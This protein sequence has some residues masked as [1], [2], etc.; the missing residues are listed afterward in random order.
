[1]YDPNL[2]NSA[3]NGAYK[4]AILFGGQSDPAFGGKLNTIQNGDY[5]EF[6]PRIGFAWSRFE[7][8]SFRGSYGI[9][10]SPRDAENYTDGAL[11]LGL[12]PHSFGPA[13]GYV[14]GKAAFPLAMGPPPGSVLYPTVQTLSSTISNGSSVTY[15]PRDMPTVYIQNLLFSVQRQL[16]LDMLVDASYVFTHGANLNFATNINQVAGSNLGCTGG[17]SACNPNPNFTSI[18][19]QNYIGWSN[20]NALQVRLQKRMSHGVNFQVNYAYSKSLDT[21]TGNGHGSGIDTYQNAFNPGVNYGLSNFNATHTVAGQV[22]Y[23]V[24]FGVGRQ[25]ALHGVLDQVLGGWRV[26]SVFQ[27]HT[28]TPFTP[29]IQGSIAN[30]IDPALSSAT[31]FPQLIGNPGLAHQSVGQ[32]GQWF[33]PAAFANPAPGTF[34]NSGRN[35]LMGPGFTNVDVSLGKTFPLHWEGIRLDIRADAINAFNHINYANPDAEVGYLSGTTVL[36]DPHAGQITGPSSGNRIVQLG[37]RLT[38]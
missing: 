4:G 22:V 26:S 15:Y 35:I 3:N 20:Y 19:A 27:W 16:P 11:G 38:F 6:A 24:P 28:G 37:A 9:F 32:Y 5:K 25:F 33:N 31:L 18:Q 30:S 34:G 29:Y 7:K 23:E 12:N 13:Q 2:P 10:D 14:S 17:Y 36:S 1:M 8:W 21:G